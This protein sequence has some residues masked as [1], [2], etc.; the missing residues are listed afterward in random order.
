MDIEALRVFIQERM[1][2]YD[3]KVRLDTGSPA[4]V[5]VVDPIVRRFTP[6]PLEPNIQKFALTRLRQEFPQLFAREGSAL[7]DL[8]IKPAQVLFEPFRREIR[9]VKRQL[10]LGDPATLSSAEAD[11][12]MYNVFVRRKVGDFARIKVRIYFPNPLSVSIGSTNFAFTATNLRFIP[13]EPQSITAE[14]MLF[15]T[16]GDLYYFDV[17][18]VAEAPGDRY[19]IG[20]SEIIGVTGL[21]AATRTTNIARAQYGINEETT[22]QLI[23]RGEKSIGERSLTTVRG[24]VAVLFEEFSDLQILQIIGFMDPEMQRDVITGG[25]LG[26]IL[27]YGV[28]GSS[29]DDGSAGTYT[30]WFS[31]PTG[32]FTARFGPVGTDISDYELTAFVSGVPVEL[33]LGEV[34]GATLISINDIYTGT[35]RLLKGLTNL[36][37]I[38]RQRGT[39]TLSGIPGGILFPN[40]LA[41]SADIPDNQVHVGGCADLMIKGQTLEDK[42]LA[43]PVVADEDVIARRENVS[44]VNGVPSAQLVDITV[45]EFNDIPASEGNQRSTLYVETGPNA[46]AYRILAKFI[47]GGPTYLVL[48]DADPSTFVTGSGYSYVI[49]DDIDIDLLEPREIKYE[50]S[51]LRTYAGSGLIDTVSGLPDFSPSGIDVTDEDVVEIINGNDRG[52]HEIS[53][54]GVAPAQ[55]T[56]D[57]LMTNTDG[58]LQYRIFRKETGIDLP[59]LRVTKLEMLDSARKPLGSFIPYRNPVDARSN[60]FQNPGR[61]AKA[62]TSV[63]EDDVLTRLAAPDEDVVQGLV[64][65]YYDAGVR[66]GDLVNINTGDNLGFYTVAMVGGAAGATIAVNQ[67]KLDRD[68]MWPDANMRYD[69]GSPSYGSFRLYFLDPVTFQVKYEETFIVIELSNGT[70]IRFRPDPEVRQEYLPT[71]VT[72]PTAAMSSANDRVSMWPP[73]AG[74]GTEISAYVHDV[75]VGDR[76]KVTFAPI[77]GSIDL[78]TASLNLDGLTL[79]VDLGRGIETVTFSGTALG[80]DTIVSQINSQL[81]ET[82]AIKY[83]RVSAPAGSYLMLRGDME[84]TLVST[85]TATALLFNNPATPG[86]SRTTFMPWLSGDFTGSGDTQNDSHKVGYYLVEQVHSSGSNVL[87]LNNLD[88]TPFAS[89]VTVG[90]ELGHFIHLEHS[91]AQRIS[92]TAMGTQGVDNLGFYYFDVECISEGYGDT[93][94]ILEGLRGLVSGFYSEGWSISVEDENLSYSMAEKPWLSVSP[95]I[96]VE[97]VSDDPTNYTELVGS[98]IQVSYE[99]MPLVQYLHSYV[100][101]KAVRVVCESP[102]ARALFPTFI[103]TYIEYYSGASETET[104]AELVKLIE[105][106]IPEEDLEVSDMHDIVRRLGS[107]KVTLPIVVVGVEHKADRSISVSR[108]EDAISTD[109]LSVMIPDDD[110]TT[111]EGASYVILDRVVS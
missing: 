96:L 77:V 71:E 1:R 95:R 7:A 60:S 53:T 87:V 102:L 12:L 6:D 81:S 17:S 46:G 25:S 26:P 89:T 61:G 11:A 10:S 105:Q 97:G 48:L 32:A 92:A 101:E 5:E 69:V 45:D 94:N 51:D 13:S 40:E 21:T 68:L 18:Y 72:I 109:R 36:T 108:S 19:N 16:D 54:G 30:S 62:G 86:A 49:V 98:N 35:N 56:L 29:S 66:V 4:S 91:G 37:W 70:E 111:V 44:F 84:I 93:Y 67:L 31:S 82:V 42:T 90:S 75:H 38:V 103:R 65:N 24:S 104:R 8:M 3:P 22:I 27:Y 73:G 55:I 43:I 58:P 79:K 2:A 80:I 63:D 34:L 83:V 88:G 99:R 57:V 41:T 106:T 85:G 100:L 14:G 50:G 64:T 76:V 107:T 110:G 52:V 59:L 28:D 9:S 39:L 74:T 47:L 33:Q 78:A 23:T 15:N 20:A